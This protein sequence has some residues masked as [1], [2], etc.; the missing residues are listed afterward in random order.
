MRLNETA[1]KGCVCLCGEA[2]LLHAWA[3]VIAC[4]NS[5]SLLKYCA[6]I[7]IFN[8]WFSGLIGKQKNST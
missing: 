2:M 8:F 7:R 5:K 3:E 6:E 4:A 1:G